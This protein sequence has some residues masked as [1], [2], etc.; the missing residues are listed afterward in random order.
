MG[1][2][3]V[4]LAGLGLCE[5]CQTLLTIEGMSADAMDSEWKCPQCEGVLTNESFGYKEDGSKIKWVGK[6]KK[7]TITKPTEDFDLGNW[8]VVM[9][10]STPFF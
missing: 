4:L 10:M 9:S 7:W 1:K 3:I 5:H 2:T 6:G 8:H